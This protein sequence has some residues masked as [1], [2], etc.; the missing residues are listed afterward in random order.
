MK[1]PAQTETAVWGAVAGAVILSILGFGFGG[2]QTSK[3]ATSAGDSR[4][5]Q[6]VSKALA[7]VCAEMFKRDAR[8]TNNLV[9]LKKID[10][11]SRGSFIEKG[12]WGKM[13]TAAELD[14]DTS[15]ACAAL[16]TTS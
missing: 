13:P 16:L 4:V 7:P 2:W 8:F 9:E 1:F 5:T 14:S 6:A 10:E 11:W 3:Q 15:K 12:G